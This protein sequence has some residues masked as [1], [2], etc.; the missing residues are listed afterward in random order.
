[1]EQ[2][3]YIIWS[4]D[5]S[6]MEDIKEFKAYFTEEYPELAQIDEDRLYQYQTQD[7]ETHLEDEKINLNI[8][9]GRPILAIASIGRW[10]GRVAGYKLIE[11]GNIRDCLRSYVNGQ[12]YD[13]F[14]VTP[15]GEFKQDEH[16]HDGTNYITYRLPRAGVSEKQLEN[17]LSDICNG[18][19]SWQQ[20]D[21]ITRKIGPDIAK[22]YGWKLEHTS[23]SSRCHER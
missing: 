11:S 9:L 6:N 8:D 5:P 20:V 16:H 12:S 10:N 18:K 7:N 14:Y 3:S 1:M 2:K 22:V 23:K 17:L 19:F 15:D 13:T 4:D 21:K